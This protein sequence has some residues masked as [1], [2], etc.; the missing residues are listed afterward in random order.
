MSIS[1]IYTTC[2]VG[3]EFFTLDI[4][5]LRLYTMRNLQTTYDKFLLKLCCVP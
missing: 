3:I 5:W 1:P 4:K 2:N